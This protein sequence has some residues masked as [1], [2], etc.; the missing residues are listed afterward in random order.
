MGN[1]TIS[2]TNLVMRV[3]KDDQYC[4]VLCITAKAPEG[5]GKIYWP[6]HRFSNHT[7]LFPKL[8]LHKQLF[9][10]RKDNQLLLEGCR[11]T[12]CCHKFFLCRVYSPSPSLPSSSHRGQRTYYTNLFI[13]YPIFQQIVPEPVAIWANVP[14]RLYGQRGSLKGSDI[15]I[16]SII[17]KELSFCLVWSSW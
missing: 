16:H 2:K 3:Q 1:V 4:C 5:K 7:T 10:Y 6:W 9:I 17:R 11:N 14:K 8:L 15:V 12:R 13:D